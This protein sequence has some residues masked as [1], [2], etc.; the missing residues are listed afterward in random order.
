MSEQFQ[1][2]KISDLFNILNKAKISAM[3][4]LSNMSNA[5]NVSNIY[6]MN[7]YSQTLSL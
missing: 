4:Y 7:E 3:A 1:N 5:Y 2:S 6:D